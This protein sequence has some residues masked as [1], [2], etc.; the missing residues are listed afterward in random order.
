[1]DASRDAAAG[2]DSGAAVDA[3]VDAGADVDACVSTGVE[4]CND[5]D[6]DCNGIVDDLDVGGDGITDCL[7]I[8]LLGAPGLRSSSNF[9][10]WL[11][12]QG[13]MVMRRDDTSPP[14]TV[15]AALLAGYDVVVLDRLLRSYSAAE[16]DVLRDYVAAGGGLISMTGYDGSADRPQSNSALVSLGVEYLPGLQDGPITRFVTHPTTA[17]L[18]SVTFAGGYYV[19][20]LA[21]ATGATN[22]VVATF[23]PV[24]DGGLGPTAGLAQERG[25]GRAWIW[26]D[27]WI[28]FDSEWTTMPEIST[29]W[30]N[31]LGWVSHQR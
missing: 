19:G 25:I 6:D 5:V 24:G 16:S 22:T 29:L 20:E 18:S 15:T 10:A 11:T 12:A 17:G 23:P 14:D 27:E 2:L 21:G 1:M 13:T 9:Q 4:T 28:E 8:L 31:V 7:H 26:G 3:S 30:A